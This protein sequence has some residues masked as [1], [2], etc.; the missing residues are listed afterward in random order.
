MNLFPAKT[1]HQLPDEI[2]K[3]LTGGLLISL[4][5]H[6]F[7]LSLQFGLPGVGLP[8]LEV[9]WDKRRAETP[10]LS[11]Q[12]AD[13]VPAAA[14]T[15]ASA[16]V[17][18]S[19]PVAGANL[20]AETNTVSPS[21]ESIVSAAPLASVPAP[22]IADAPKSTTARGIQL[23]APRVAVVS[24]P[25]PEKKTHTKAAKAKKSVTRIPVAM[26]RPP[27]VVAVDVPDIITQNNFRTD[28][29]SVAVRDP[30]ENKKELTQNVEQ[31]MFPDPVSQSDE[32]S[33]D[34]PPV[35]VSRF[36]PDAQQRERREEKILQ[37][38][39]ELL[40][41][42]IAAPASTQQSVKQ[43]EEASRKQLAEAVRA[44]ADAALALRQQQ[45]A[46]RQQQ[47]ILQEASKANASVLAATALQGID[48]MKLVDDS[49]KQQMQAE[50]AQREQQRK[51]RQTAM[52][53]ARQQAEEREEELKRQRE[54]ALR[55]QQQMEMQI[56]Q[57]KN[58]ELQE[59][60]KMEKL[61]EQRAQQ[62]AQEALQKGQQERLEMQRAENARQQAQQ[63]EQALAQQREQAAIAVAKAGGTNKLASANDHPMSAGKADGNSAVGKSNMSGS[64]SNSAG[65]AASNAVGSGDKTAAFVLPQ[66]LLSSDLAN[67]SRE[68][69]RGLDLLRGTPPLPRADTEERPRRRSVLGSAEKD[70]Q[71]RMYIDSWKQKIERNGNLNFSQTSR[72]KARG[73][74]VVTVAI[75]SDGSVEEI[76][77]HRSSGRADLDQAVR[78]IVRINAKYAAFPP[79]IAAQYDV[80]EV[81]RVWNFDDGLRI[82]E[83]LR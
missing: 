37:A 34:L 6:A 9:P 53:T 72:D 18:R 75:R 74:P 57:A 20:K 41:E 21:K 27:G 59:R 4:L 64:H 42:K 16:D 71:L 31:R 49:L 79:N 7:I 10:E 40:Q 68:Q 66:S 19:D 8:G 80:I 61:A 54:E 67:R 44:E 65:S 33:A 78:N 46:E 23:L 70:I 3:R 50:L 32:A 12:I 25:V 15:A 56:A 14:T 77:I 55:K 29:F 63:T 26:P 13:V 2:K 60:Q 39:R 69:A 83:E 43:M 17:T 38:T 35:A 82:L 58:E 48:K 1:E 45:E 52:L 62:Q 73:D 47:R 81:R 36:E 11:V 22:V 51:E 5:V 24:V 76:T 28:T 30:E